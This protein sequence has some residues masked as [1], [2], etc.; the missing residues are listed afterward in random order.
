MA[1]EL[2]STKRISLR[3]SCLP[4]NDPFPFMP[5]SSLSPPQGPALYFY[6]D[7][8][9]TPQDFQNIARIGQASKLDKVVSTGRFGLGFNATYH[10]TDLPVRA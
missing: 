8:S 9:F 2:K 4:V 3:S 7:A 10:C 6:N 1:G 5:Y